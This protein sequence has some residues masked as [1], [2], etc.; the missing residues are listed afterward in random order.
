MWYPKDI[1]GACGGRVRSVSTREF[2]FSLS[3]VE[4]RRHFAFFAFSHQNS[5]IS[6]YQMGR[7]AG[8]PNISEA[9]RGALIALSHTNHTPN[10]QLAYRYECDEKT[11]RNVLDR[12]RE[13]D[14]ENIDPL[15]SQAHQP[16][17]KS[18]RPPVITERLQ[19]QLI[20]HATKNRVQRRKAWVTIARE[21][22]CMASAKAINGAFSRAGYGR[23]PPRYKPP[24]SPEQKNRRLEF[25]T[26]W[27]PIIEGKEHMVVHS[28]ETSVRV[29]EARG[30]MW[31]TRTKD[32]VYHKDCVDVRYRGYTEMMFWGCYTSE[33]R[34]PSYIF[35]KETSDEK[36]K[37]Q[38][39][40]DDRNMDYHLQ[41]QIIKDEFLTEQAK[42]P[43]SRRLKRIP[44]PEGVLLQRNPNSKG[45]VD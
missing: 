28:D 41:Q 1:N 37:S 14:E 27:L 17:P 35:G 34:G 45:G 5:A 15:S 9:T 19:R 16:R 8:K 10:R 38:A 20:R 23:Y 33:L 3:A 2:F 26:E 24:L 6:S 40:L 21:I 43:K 11:V 25:V 4:P 30:Q 32:E 12:A 42:K 36:A 7:T 18:G 22:G 13:A 44:K 29:G 39:D 31:V